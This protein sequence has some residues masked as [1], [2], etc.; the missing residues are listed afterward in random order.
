[1]LGVFAFGVTPVFVFGAEGAVCEVAGA[2]SGAM[3]VV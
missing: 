3:D 2:V 1:V